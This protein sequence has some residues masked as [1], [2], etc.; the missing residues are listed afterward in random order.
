MSLVV[1]HGI[2]TVLRQ[3]LVLRQTGVPIKAL[4]SHRARDAR[5]M[6]L[7][8]RFY[9]GLLRLPLPIDLLGSLGKLEDRPVQLYLDSYMQ[10]LQG[11]SCC[12][13][14]LAARAQR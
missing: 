2:S 9:G 3:Q 14:Q 8:I 11:K 12:E 1:N 6:L 10:Y 7:G 5:V 4:S 13:S